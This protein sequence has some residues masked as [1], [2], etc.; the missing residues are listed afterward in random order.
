MLLL[1][2]CTA[3]LVCNTHS[4]DTWS[5]ISTVCLVFF[6]CVPRVFPVSEYCFSYTSRFIL[7][8]PFAFNQSSY[9]S[10]PTYSL[11]IALQLRCNTHTYSPD[12]VLL[13]LCWIEP[14]FLFLFG[15]PDS[16][17]TFVQLSD[18]QGKC[19]VLSIECPTLYP[20]VHHWV[21]HQVSSLPCMPH[22]RTQ[23]WVL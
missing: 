12:S 21:L 2:I 7:S 5:S 19:W 17:N 1:F 18:P 20:W 10:F 22:S 3:A 23:T 13:W 6:F 11:P 8:V 9:N 14:F 15:T 4:L 16:S